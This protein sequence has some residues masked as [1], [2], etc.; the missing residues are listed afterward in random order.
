M[1]LGDWRPL[2]VSC[3]R[4]SPAVQR[5]S[6]L[7]S[8]C[9]CPTYFGADGVSIHRRMKPRACGEPLW[10]LT[11][12]RRR[13]DGPRRAC[14]VNAA[15]SGRQRWS[16]CQSYWHHNPA[17]ASAAAW[18]PTPRVL[19]LRMPEG[20]ATTP[21]HDQKAVIACGL[22]TTAAALNN[23][24]RVCSKYCTRNRSIIL[25][26]RRQCWGRYREGF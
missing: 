12:L 2:L 24:I 16:S 3:L 14:I 13:H 11:P 4:R 8:V 18:P 22:K 17:W 20:G 6:M 21:L 25:L 1:Q 9:D 19:A 15:N 7:L 23:N 10:Q 26:S 5:I